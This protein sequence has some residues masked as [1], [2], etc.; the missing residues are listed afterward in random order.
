M[1]RRPL[2]SG[3]F[4]CANAVCAAQF[5]A[6][7]RAG[8]NSRTGEKNREGI[9]M[10]AEITNHEFAVR[11]EDG[12]AHVDLNRPDDGNAMTRHMMTKIAALVTEL[13]HK[14][15]IRVVAL[16]ARGTHF[17]R[18]RDASGEPK[19]LSA[20][21]M[22]HKSFQPVLGTYSAFMEAP[23]PVV[24]LVQGSAVGFGAAMAAACD[25]TLASD[26]ARFSFPEIKHGIPPTLA[27]SALGPRLHP[28]TLSYLIYSG[29]EI[30]AQE[31]VTFGLASTVYPK[32]SFE[33]DAAAFLKTM[34]SRPRLILETIKKYQTRL[35]ELSP[36]MATEYAGTLM[37]VFRTAGK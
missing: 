20:Y 24:A 19:D 10:S 2:L 15:D 22:R 5:T 23:V 18:G 17:C 37:A 6:A 30:S 28:K 11:E 4:Y 1:A 7:A 29:E 26:A 21:D 8:Q 27:M 9:C 3:R 16:E 12:I 36:S 13:A 31:A 33:R 25:V 35:P 14:P 34:A 32:A